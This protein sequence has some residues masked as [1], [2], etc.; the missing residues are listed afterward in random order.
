MSGRIGEELRRG[1]YRGP[2]AEADGGAALR[3]IAPLAEGIDEPALAA[4]LHIDGQLAL[5]DDMLH[6][7]DRT[8]MMHS[9]EVRVPF[10]D[11]EVVEYCA[12]IPTTLKVHR[13]RTK[14][15]LK[16]AA[17]GIVPQRIVDKRKI[18]FLRGATSGWLQAQM[19]YTIADYLLAPAPRYAEFLDRA[20]VERLV[21]QH[22]QGATGDSHLLTAILMLEVW[23]DTYLPRATG[24]SVRL[25]GLTGSG[26]D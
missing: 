21:T 10:L 25:R 22:R 2:L 1:L 4:T 18:G 17:R 11:H 7:Y 23:L 16:E 5:P 6:Y 12:R 9:L 8:S 13:L 20:T 26:H 14:H 19:G 15:I 3:A 24:D